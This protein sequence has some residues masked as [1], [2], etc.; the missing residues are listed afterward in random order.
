VYNDDPS[1]SGYEEDY[2]AI[3]SG[4]Q[5]DFI[6]ELTDEDKTYL[7]LKWGKTYRPEEWIRLE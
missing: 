5:D 6:D 1:A 7:R 3:Q 4:G 2:F